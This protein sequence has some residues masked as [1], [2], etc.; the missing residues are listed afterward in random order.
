MNVSNSFKIQKLPD[1]IMV[2]R[3]EWSSEPIRFK[4]IHIKTSLKIWIE[5]KIKKDEIKVRGERLMN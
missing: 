1:L 3:H 5:L 2:F 4:R